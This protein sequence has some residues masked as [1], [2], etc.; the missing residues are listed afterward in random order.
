MRSHPFLSREPTGRSLVLLPASSKSWNG[1][2]YFGERDGPLSQMAPFLSDFER[3]PLG[4]VNFSS[5]P[6]TTVPTDP[7]CLRV[8]SRDTMPLSVVW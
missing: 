8:R 6:S 7:W 3:E 1:P 5:I 4:A 2:M